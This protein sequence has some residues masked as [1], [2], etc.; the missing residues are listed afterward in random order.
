MSEKKDILSIIP[1]VYYDLI[2][3]MIP[4]I[5]FL[6]L[7]FILTKGFNRQIF[8][9][10]II[11]GEKIFS[12]VGFL[13]IGLVL[14]YAFGLMFDVLGDFFCVLF[15]KGLN[16]I[17]NC[18][19]KEGLAISCELD[20]FHGKDFVP[21]FIKITAEKVFFRSLFLISL[22]FYFPNN[23]IEFIPYFNIVKDL[24]PLM[25]FILVI[26]MEIYLRYRFKKK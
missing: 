22:I 8:L 16:K 26:Y 24:I 1:E 12:M 23:N 4:G 25:F 17:F 6:L 19:I 3:R 10:H 7:F 20:E 18:K 9:E 21:I 15:I 5:I 11:I 13:L 2:A 14:S